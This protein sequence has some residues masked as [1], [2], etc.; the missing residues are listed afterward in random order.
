M[1][2]VKWEHIVKPRI[3]KHS[4]GKILETSSFCSGDYDGTEQAHSGQWGQEKRERKE[5]WVGQCSPW[6]TWQGRRSPHPYLTQGAGLSPAPEQFCLLLG[7]GSYLPN[8]HFTASVS[9][10]IWDRIHLSLQTAQPSNI[11][12]FLTTCS[13]I[14]TR[15]FSISHAPA[16]P[17]TPPPENGFHFWSMTCSSSCL[18]WR[19]EV[20][21]APAATQVPLPWSPVSSHSC[22]EQS[23]CL[24]QMAW[25]DL[26]W[27]FIHPLLH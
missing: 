16:L 22:S 23:G 25:L 17:P 2:S 19:Q 10:H 27:N 5:G 15:P 1:L 13:G 18:M 8:L 12:D 21:W 11:A 6:K 4:A 7:S 20:A 26:H 14:I 24:E 3:F 9:P